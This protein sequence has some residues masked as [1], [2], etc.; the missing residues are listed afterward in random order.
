MFQFPRL[1]PATVCVPEAGAG[2]QVPAGSPIRRPTA[3]AGMCPW[4][5]TIAACRVLRR[6][7]VPRHPP[8]ALGILRAGIGRRPSFSRNQSCM[9]RSTNWRIFVCVTLCGSQGAAGAGP[10]DRTP[11]ASRRDEVHDQRAWSSDGTRPSEMMSGS[12]F[13]C[14]PR[15]E[16][17]QPHLPVRLPCYD[18]TPLTSHTFGASPHCWLGRR[19]RVQSTR[20]V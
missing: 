20:V 4:P 7:P 1:P 19:L 6:L 3:R 14:L 9:M 12:L 5:W 17:I 2:P 18:F 16:V 8:C 10:G 13:G 11:C 15:K